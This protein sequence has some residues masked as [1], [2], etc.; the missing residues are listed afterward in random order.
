[1]TCGCAKTTRIPVKVESVTEVANN[2]SWSGDALFYKV[3]TDKGTFF[4]RTNGQLIIPKE[5]YLIKRSTFEG[6]NYSFDFLE[7]K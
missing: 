3:V 6:T 2:S 5:G 7:E 4:F 1:M